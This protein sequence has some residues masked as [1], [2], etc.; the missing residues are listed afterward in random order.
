MVMLMAENLFQ[1]AHLII[2][3]LRLAIDLGS[4]PNFSNCRVTATFE[5]LFLSNAYLKPMKWR[6]KFPPQ[7]YILLF[8]NIKS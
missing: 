2:S 5:Y 6:V 3:L 4:N 7:I 1:I 8:L